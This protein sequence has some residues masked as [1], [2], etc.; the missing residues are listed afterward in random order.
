M[1]FQEQL[2]QFGEWAFDLSGPWQKTMWA[3]IAMVLGYLAG[4]IVS[5]TVTFIGR[6]LSALRKHEKTSQT[7]ETEN[8]TDSVMLVIVA[9]LLRGAGLLAGVAGA[10][11]VFGFPIERLRATAINAGLAIGILVLAWFIGAWLGARVRGFGSKI[12]RG[13]H[14]GGETMFGFLSSVVRIATLAIGLIAGL[15]LFGFPIA[16]LVAVIGAAGL[17]IALALQD[18]LKAVAAGVIIAVFR[19]YRIGDYVRI[20]DVEG[21]VQEITP[22]TTV[23]TTVDNREIVVT[24]DQVW[25]NVIINSSARPYRRLELVFSISYEDDIDKALGVIRRVYESDSRV[26]KAPPVWLQVFTLN[27]SSVDI[28]VRAWCNGSVM[29]DLHSD[30]LRLVKQAFGREGITIPYPHQVA[31][32][33]DTP[34]TGYDTLAAQGAPKAPDHGDDRTSG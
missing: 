16:S 33:K 34:S 24:N 7:S 10:A 15:Q 22:F 23:L 6:R 18:T 9:S 32:M 14:T 27:A 2:R 1:E 8:P 21:S 26:H 25:S 31:I 13:Q 11:W 30:M 4:V 3:G 19:P 12:S 28:R 20:A 29:L 5:R 17:A